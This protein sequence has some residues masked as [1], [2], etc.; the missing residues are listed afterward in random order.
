MLSFVIGGI[1]GAKSEP[2]VIEMPRVNYFSNF[3]VVPKRISQ[4]SLIGMTYGNEIVACGISISQESECFT[5]QM[6]DGLGDTDWIPAPFS[7]RVKRSYAA[8]SRFSNES[9]IVSGGEKSDPG[10]TNIDKLRTSEIFND[11]RFSDGPR[12]PIKISMHCMFKLNKSHVVSTG[13]RDSSSR[14]LHRVDLLNM[15]WDWD[16]LPRMHTGRYGHACGHYRREEIIVAGGLNVHGS[17][18]YSIKFSEW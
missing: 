3:P 12:L 1:S 4:S 10:D 2:E 9:W 11:S 14:M 17:E 8:I 5:L 6:N 7:M 18:L 16:R 15:N 13:G